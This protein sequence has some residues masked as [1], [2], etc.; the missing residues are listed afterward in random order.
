MAPTRLS[1]GHF[2]GRYVFEVTIVCNELNIT[3]K[4]LNY[5][6]ISIAF[7]TTNLRLEKKICEKLQK[8]K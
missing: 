5:F 7:V 2:Q 8:Y 3:L 1:H 6:I 4:A